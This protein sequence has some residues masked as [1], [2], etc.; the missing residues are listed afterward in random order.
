MVELRSRTSGCRQ[1]P[2]CVRIAALSGVTGGLGLTATIVGAT[3]L[4]KPDRV[5]PEMPLHV[6]SYARPGIITLSL[7][8]S[9]LAT[10]LVMALAAARAARHRRHATARRSTKRLSNV[11]NR[12]LP[13]VY[14]VARE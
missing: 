14:P 11:S 2:S 1:S 5:D 10:S 13:N 12:D 8:I 4:A 6:R 3:L 9:V 7:G